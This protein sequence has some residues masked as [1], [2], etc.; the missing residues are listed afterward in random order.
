M[1]LAALL[2]LSLTAIGLRPL[3]GQ[4]QSPPAC[5]CTIWP[6]TA[7][8]ALAS[9][10]DTVAIEVGVKFQSSVSG[11]ITGIRFYKGAGNAGT[12]T[13]TLWTSSGTQLACAERHSLSLSTPRPQSSPRH[14][15]QSICVQR[16]PSQYH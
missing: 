1:V 11:Y 14:A 3:T 13:G 5:P 6:S 2:V 8:P 16:S 15:P 7:T 9:D 10:P 4:A 12:H